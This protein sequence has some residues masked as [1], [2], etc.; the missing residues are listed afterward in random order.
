MPVMDTIEH[1][2]VGEISR[3]AG[4]TVRTLHHY[5][6]IGLVSPSGRTD[7]GYRLYGRADIE[8]LQE[9]LLFRELDLGLGEIKEII[10]APAYHREA[11]LHQQRER[12]VARA[13]RLL[14]IADAVERTINAQQTGAE[15]T[16]E[17]ILEVFGDFDPGEYRAEAEERWGG[18]EAYADSMRR[19]ASYTAA[20][21]RKLRAE[22]A[23]ID[24]ELLE[25][26]A[27]GVPPTSAEAMDLAERHRGHI[28]TWFYECTPEIHAGLGQMYVADERFRKNIDRAG[29]GFAGY[30]AAA[31][32]ANGRRAGVS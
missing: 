17:E 7:S 26:K 28:T 18:T 11:V 10:D 23:A 1:K 21:W 16:A 27:A 22:A 24:R 25:L 20:D 2:T 14:D 12:L 3:L 29:K 31:I 4:I 8:R 9:V 5:D 30:L 13:E 15:M 32:E 19:T 6:E